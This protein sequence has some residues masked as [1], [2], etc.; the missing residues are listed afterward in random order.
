MVD[1]HCESFGIVP[2]CQFHTIRSISRDELN[3]HMDD[4]LDNTNLYWPQ[5][6]IL[7]LNLNKTNDTQVVCNLDSSKEE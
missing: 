1:W 2:S 4:M 5:E 3:F 6:Q 7:N